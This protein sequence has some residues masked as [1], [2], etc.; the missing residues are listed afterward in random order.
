MHLGGGVAEPH[1]VDVT[2]DDEGRAVVQ[3]LYGG[4]QGV[5][6]ALGKKQSQIVAAH[7]VEALADGVD[8]IAENVR[9]L[10]HEERILSIEIWEC[11]FHSIA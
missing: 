11:I 1:G 4:L 7:F 3:K 9:E 5:G 6:V 8:L 10:V 2:R